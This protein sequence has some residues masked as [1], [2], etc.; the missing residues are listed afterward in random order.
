MDPAWIDAR[1][2]DSR[3]RDCLASMGIYLF[4]RK[5]LVDLLTK[6]DYHDFGR[7][8]FPASVRSH[9]VQ[10]H[11]FDGY[12]EDIGTIRS[13]FDANLALGG[14]DRP[15]DLADDQNPIYTRARFLAPS[16]IEG[17]TIRNTLLADG[18]IVE[19]G[20]TIENSVIG[21]R[22]HIGRNVTIRNSI[23]MG[24]DYYQSEKERAESIAA[25]R[26]PLGIGEGSLIE[27]AI[28]DKNAAIGRNVRIANERG[29]QACG[30]LPEMVIADGIVVIQKGAVLPDG[31]QV[32]SDVALAGYHA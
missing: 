13:F 22:C 24:V 7:E 27:T 3:G 2:I 32:P 5:A 19:A 30:E 20:T 9:N 10:V 18:C 25:G 14:T 16:R 31:W 6:T 23:L 21:V 12:W 11:L 29:I 15:F 28:I 1:G 26:P 17:A 8:I 4:N